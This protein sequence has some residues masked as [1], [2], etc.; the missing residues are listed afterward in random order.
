MNSVSDTQVTIPII[1]LSKLP[2]TTKALTDCH[3]SRSVCQQR[4][5][6]DLPCLKDPDH[7][8]GT[9]RNPTVIVSVNFA[10][11]GA[12]EEVS[13]AGFQMTSC[14]ASARAVGRIT[15]LINFRLR[16]SCKTIRQV[17]GFVSHA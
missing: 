12:D 5:H 1:P 16:E 10:R 6:T 3:Y 15:G 8:L 9:L 14:D 2:Q 7:S 13:R 11:S 4:S 17:K